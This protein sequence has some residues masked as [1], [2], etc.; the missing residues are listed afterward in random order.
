MVY[1]LFKLLR[2]SNYV[3]VLSESTVA[4]ERGLKAVPIVDDHAEEKQM[5][6]CIHLLKNTYMKRSSKEF[7]SM[8]SES[9]SKFALSDII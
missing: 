9:I 3:T 6:G 8:L 4:Y 1:L 2:E 7:I 5:E